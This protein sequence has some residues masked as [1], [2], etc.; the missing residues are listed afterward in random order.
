[1]LSIT[2][3]PGSSFDLTWPDGSTR[4]VT[5]LSSKYFAISNGDGERVERSPFIIRVPSS[6]DTATVYGVARGRTVAIGVDAPRSIRVERD[7]IKSRQAVS[8]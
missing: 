5:V 4:T 6:Q 1:M 7:D 8:A 2:R 3:R